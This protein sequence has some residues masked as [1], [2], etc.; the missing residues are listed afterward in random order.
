MCETLGVLLFN[1]L[2]EYFYFFIVSFEQLV[3]I[4]RVKLT[5]KMMKTCRPNDVVRGVAVLSTVNYN[6]DCGT[7][8]VGV[9]S[10]KSKVS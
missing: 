5:T 3:A 7:C 4:T 6:N 10:G 1:C 8:I 9:L 2:S